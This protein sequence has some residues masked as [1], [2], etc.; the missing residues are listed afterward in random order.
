MTPPL[1]PPAPPASANDDGRDQAPG[2]SYNPVGTRGR[3]EM[4]AIW[5][6][7]SDAG[8]RFVLTMA[9]GKAAEEQPAKRR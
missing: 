3:I 2:W 9:R 1:S 6:G 4:L 5:D 7:L 8:K